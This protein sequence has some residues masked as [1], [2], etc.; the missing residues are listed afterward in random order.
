MPAAGAAI[1]EF[2]PTGNV[3]N[4]WGDPELLDRRLHSL[5]LRHENNV[6]IAS[7][8]S[9]MVQKYSHDGKLLLQRRQEGRA[10]FV[11][12]H[13]KGKPLN[14]NAA[15]FFMPSSILSTGRTATSMCPTAKAASSNRRVA[16]MDQRR[17]SS[18]ASGSPKAWRPC[19]A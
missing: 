17:T 1:I 13:A 7:A 10:R 6:W 4:S 2:D 3:V 5:P 14:S 11:R 15:A 12:R 18:C 8:P 19:T 16:V 9:G